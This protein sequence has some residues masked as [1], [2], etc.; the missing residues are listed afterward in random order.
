L[1]CQ[2]HGVSRGPRDH[3]PGKRGHRIQQNM[4][5]VRINLDVNRHKRRR[6]DCGR[7]IPYNLHTYKHER[8]EERHG[9]DII[10]GGVTV[11]KEKSWN[12]AG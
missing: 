4:V 3:H 1:L 5:R 7:C 2:S 11:D 6:I 9:L 10:S 12:T 8:E